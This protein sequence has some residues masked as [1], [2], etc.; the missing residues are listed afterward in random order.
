[1][2]FRRAGLSESSAM[3][4]SSSDVCGSNLIDDISKST[5]PSDMLQL[6]DKGMVHRADMYEGCKTLVCSTHSGPERVVSISRHEFSHV[7]TTIWQHRIRM[8]F[9]FD[10]PYKAGSSTTRV[11]SNI[12]EN[13]EYDPDSGYSRKH[14]W[15]H[16]WD[17]C[18]ITF[19]I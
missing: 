4:K 10:K 17:F 8:V 6:L 11:V 18:A 13:S 9:R 7:L 2:Y 12:A 19:R 3:D 5:H 16:S 14:S 15:S 1:M